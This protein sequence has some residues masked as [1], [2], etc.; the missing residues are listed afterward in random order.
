[1]THLDS[2]VHLITQSALAKSLK[3]APENTFIVPYR[4]ATNLL[5]EEAASACQVALL[6]A[7]YEIEDMVKTRILS[8]LCKALNRRVGAA[9][10]KMHY[11]TYFEESLDAMDGTG[12]SFVQKHLTELYDSIAQEHLA[13]LPSE[14][15]A[16]VASSVA[17][18]SIYTFLSNVSLIRPLKRDCETSHYSR[19]G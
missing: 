18:Y 7:I 12:T 2:I 15:A 1:M 17:T 16:M 5:Y 4:P 3:N 19:L 11:G 9:I 6:P 8:P 13:S 14:Y 10:T